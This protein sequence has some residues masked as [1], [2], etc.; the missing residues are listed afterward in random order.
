MS[1]VAAMNSAIQAAVDVVTRGRPGI[2]NK[3]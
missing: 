1:Q 3:R 2:V